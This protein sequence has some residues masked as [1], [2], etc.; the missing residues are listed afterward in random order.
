VLLLFVLGLAA[1]PLALLQ[2]LPIKIAV[3]SVLGDHPLP[4]FVG[5]LVPDPLAASREGR[6][7]VAVVLLVGTA[8]L[9]RLQVL[10]T[11]L[12]T[13]WT[14]QRMVLDFRA[15]LFRRAQRVSLAYHDTRGTTDSSYRILYDAPSIQHL[16][17]DGVLP[18]LTSA[19][20]FGAMLLVMALLSLELAGVALA[21]APVLFLATHHYGRRLRQR[22]RS[23]KK[24]ESASLSVVQE[25][26]SAVRVVKAFG[27]EEREESRFEEVSNRGIRENLAVARAESVFGIVIGLTLAVGTASVLW[28]GVRRVEARALTVGDLLLVMAYVAQMYEPLRTMSKKLAGLQGSLASAERAFELLDEAKEVP[29]KPDARSLPSARGAIRFERVSFTYDGRKPALA[30]L[31]FEVEAGARVGIA[32]RTGAGKTTLVSLL[33]RFYDVTS[34]RILL[35]GV[36]LRDIRLRD[37]RNQFAIVLQEP[38]LFS[39]SIAENIAYARPEAGA[40]EIVAAARA[41]NAHDFIAGLP[42]GYAT[43]VGE[44]GMK[45]SG[46]ERQRIS[47]ARAFLKDAPILVLDEPTSAVDTRTE[48]GILEAMERLMAGRTTF[49]IAHRLGTLTGCD[50]RLELEQGRLVESDARVAEEAPRA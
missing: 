47:L 3:D 28:I 40:D 22:W 20:S 15:R 41:A 31:S 1:T 7:A 39:A 46:G 21:I 49:I 2:P 48:R 43:L 38:V 24:L 29:E 6:L 42:D 27:R 44:R 36:D 13:T 45:L 12:L 34:G 32:G 33:M 19:V 4:R 18:F 16:A 14:S 26:L 50:V 30:D 5:A 8:L 23:V 37:L 10:G 11:W 17:I 9:L 35:D 25:A